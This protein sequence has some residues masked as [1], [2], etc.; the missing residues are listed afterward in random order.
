MSL[1]V[2]SFLKTLESFACHYA[3]LFLFLLRNPSS[4]KL[5]DLPPIFVSHLL[6]NPKRIFASRQKHVSRMKSSGERNPGNRR[7]DVH[8]LHFVSFGLACHEEKKKLK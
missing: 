7:L 5:S 3:V 1:V 4:I 8:G 2:A 6:S